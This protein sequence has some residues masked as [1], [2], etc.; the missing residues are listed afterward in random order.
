ML[1]GEVPGTQY[2]LSDSGWMD[3]EI[4]DNWFLSHFL[5]HAPPARPLLL[6]LD[7]HSSH[8]NPQFIAKAAFEQVI[9][10]CFP[11]NTTHL[12]QPLDKG[13]FVPLSLKRYWNEESHQYLCKHPGQVINDYSFNTVFIRAWG[14]AMTI[15]NASGAFGTTAIYPFD[16]VT[17]TVLSSIHNLSQ[18]T[19][20]HY[21]PLL[22]PA[23]SC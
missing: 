10:F 22:S 13:I 9:V 5:V 8:F 14:Q 6:L 19:G 21:I 1:I 7:G 12:T 16:R 17:K 11:P 23:P 3:S 15:P 20:L 18:S 4:F 2:A